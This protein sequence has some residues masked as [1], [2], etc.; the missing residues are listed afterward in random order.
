LQAGIDVTPHDLPQ[1]TGTISSSEGAM[2]FSVRISMTSSD[3]HR[4]VDIL[5]SD[6]RVCLFIDCR[7]WWWNRVKYL[8]QNNSIDIKAVRLSCEIGKNPFNIPFNLNATL[9]Q[10]ERPMEHQIRKTVYNQYVL[11]PRAPLTKRLKARLRKYWDPVAFAISMLA[12]KARLRKHWVAFAVSVLVVG[13]ATALIVN[14]IT[15]N[16][17]FH[18]AAGTRPA[19]PWA[20]IPAI[21]KPA[22]IKPNTI[23]M[24]LNNR[25]V[26]MSPDGKLH[27][28][29]GPDG[30][31]WNNP[32]Q[33]QDLPQK[34]P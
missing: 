3:F 2:V 6:N 33:W 22:D 27:E 18:S 26:I 7:C 23:Y 24:G 4:L 1:T 13:F 28:Y 25:P 21:P 15:R 29:Q 34:K 20:G 19:N 9:L 16:K 30:S 12:I 5:L 31:D 14:P 8:V 10:D 32:E 17:L 11:Y